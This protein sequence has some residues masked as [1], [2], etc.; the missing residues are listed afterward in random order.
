MFERFSPRSPTIVFAKAKLTLGFSLLSLV[1]EYDVCS[2]TYNAKLL[3]N[4]TLVWKSG[5][6]DVKKGDF[7]MFE[8][9]LS[10]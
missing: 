6:L 9:D 7:F 8:F 2:R 5:N 1:Q 10:E 3:G 4:G